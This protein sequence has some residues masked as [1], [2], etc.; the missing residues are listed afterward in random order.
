MKLTIRTLKRLIKEAV[1]EATQTPNESNVV[2]LD[3]TFDGLV[4]RSPGGKAVN[5]DKQLEDQQGDEY[6]EQLRLD[7]SFE[8]VRDSGAAFVYDS[9]TPDGTVPWTTKSGKQLMVT[10]LAQWV[11]D[12]E[13]SFKGSAGRPH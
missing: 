12:N 7:L 4:V 13:Y 9:E 2:V 5:V 3:S 6:D 1:Q 11:Q 8:L 10:P